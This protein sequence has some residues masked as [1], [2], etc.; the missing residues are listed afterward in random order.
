MNAD[1]AFIAS[2]FPAQNDAFVQERLGNLH[3]ASRQLLELAAGKGATQAEVACSE[4]GGLS[5]NVRL[6]EVETVEYNQDRGI[7]VTVYVGR[8]KGSASTSDMSRDSLEATID[9]AMAIASYTEEDPA[10]GLAEREW[11]A[12]QARDFDTWHPWEITAD[13]AIDLALECEQAGREADAQVRNSEGASVTSGSGLS[14]YANSLGFVGASA[15]THHS[16]GAAF[17]AGEGDAMQRDGYYDFRIEASELSDARFVGDESARRAVARLK[18]RSLKTGEYPVIFSNEMARGLLGHFL[19]AISGSAQ[20]RKSTFLLDSIGQNV[21]PS[22]I[23]ISERPF[24][25]R[26]LNSSWFDGDGVAT[27]ESDLVTD[28]VIQR[29]LLGTYSARKLGM[30]PTG[31]AGGAHNL[32]VS[33]NAAGLDE[34]LGDMRNGLL[35]TQLMGQGVNTVTGDYS[36]GA[37]GF[38][39]ENG[40][41]AYPVDG[42]TVAG[43][44]KDMLASIAAIGAD[45]DHRSQHSIGSVY[46]PKMMVAGD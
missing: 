31:N 42:V 15:G 46:L 16:I 1:P 9:Q 41:I 10:A 44:L 26:G 34:L 7:G 2:T 28:G 12:T 32:L 13:Q 17:I 11:L 40:E 8:R 43:N 18:P 22:W 38:W 37:G 24:L 30:Q 27:Q 6:G 45:H 21:L 14:V 25:A 4:S 5:V 33:S 23:S 35:I 29:Y 19:G 39:I 36:R 3:D 20:Y